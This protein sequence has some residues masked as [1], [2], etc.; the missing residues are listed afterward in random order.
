MAAFSVG[1]AVQTPQGKG[2]VR[3]V[4]NGG[5]LLVQIQARMVVPVSVGRPRTPGAVESRESMPSIIA[6]L[7]A[8][9]RSRI[10]PGSRLRAGAGLVIRGRARPRAR[11]HRRPRWRWLHGLAVRGRGV[12]LRHRRR[13]SMRPCRAGHAEPGAAAL[14]PL[15]RPRRVARRR[16][17]RRRTP[18][19]L[20]HER[21]RGICT[22]PCAAC[23]SIPGSQRRR[24]AP[25]LVAPRH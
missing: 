25:S 23:G 10:G 20:S 24:D 19:R 1:D 8:R 17:Q 16:L 7:V 13:R 22:W 3:E 2:V 18:A 6:G 5:R 11:S 15:R 14:H 4:R 9:C 21:L 12:P